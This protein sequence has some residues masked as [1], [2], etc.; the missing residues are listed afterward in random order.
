MKRVNIHLEEVWLKK[1][2]E[3]CQKIKDNKIP[4]YW[5]WGVT[6]ADLIRL[7]VAEFYGFESPYVHTSA[8]RLLELLKELKIRR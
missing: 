4:D 8:N 7:A 6:R 2:D 5:V 1:L 3:I